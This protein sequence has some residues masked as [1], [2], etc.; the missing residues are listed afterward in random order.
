MR[1]I[2]QQRAAIEVEGHMHKVR[3]GR[4]GKWHYENMSWLP[5]VVDWTLRLSGTKGWGRRHATAL[6]LEKATFWLKTLPSGFD[7]MR[8]LLVTDLHI[9]GLPELVPGLIDLVRPL[10]FDLCLLGGDYSFAVNTD[11]SEAEDFMQRISRVLVGC[12]DVVGVLGNH[13]R[14]RMAECLQAE[15]IRMLV[16]EHLCLEKGGERLFITGLDD[17]HYYQADDIHLADDG[18]PSGACKLMLCHSPEKYQEAAIKGYHLYCAGHTHGGQVCLPGGFAP[19]TC[20]TVPRSLAKGAWAYKQ[21][22]GYT[23]RGVGTSSIPARFFCAPE[24]TLIT[25]RR[26]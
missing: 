11:V 9:D 4:W 6:V 18:I 22:Q 14:Y 13:D 17:G 23:S 2:S 8:L 7:H 16:N 19:V 15:G 5:T 10:D 20:A 21:M 12:G 1:S 26:G 25:L 3:R 24:I